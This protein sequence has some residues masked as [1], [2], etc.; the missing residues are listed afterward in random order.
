[1]SG[2]PHFYFRH[3]VL[4]I[5]ALPQRAITRDPIAYDDPEEFVPER[6][7]GDP[8]FDSDKKEALQPFSVGPRNCI[9]KK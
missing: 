3:C 8:R 2:T 4:A 7:L 1:M 9:G 5:Y 6:W